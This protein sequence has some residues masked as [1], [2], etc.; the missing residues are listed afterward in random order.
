MI[1]YLNT[2]AGISPLIPKQPY[3]YYYYFRLALCMDFCSVTC[4]FEF[5]IFFLHVSVLFVEYSLDLLTDYIIV[6]YA[7]SRAKKRRLR[8][9]KCDRC[10]RS[11]TLPQ[12]LRRHQRVECGKEKQFQCD[13]CLVKFYYKQELVLHY[14]AKKHKI[15]S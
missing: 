5:I 3:Y 14:F 13:Q 4:L 2:Y 12:N 15:S 8:P 6:G 11:Y 10:S 9:F 7:Y 1:Y